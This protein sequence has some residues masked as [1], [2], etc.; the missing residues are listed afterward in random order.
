MAKDKEMLIALYDAMYAAFNARPS[1]AGDETSDER[2]PYF[3]LLGPGETVLPSDFAGAPLMG[4]NKGSAAALARFSAKVDT[5]PK[6]SPLYSPGGFISK[7]YEEFVTGAK[8]EDAPVSEEQQR[9]YDAASA[10]IWE[11]SAEGAAT[12][13]K[14]YLAYQ[15]AQSAYQ[16]SLAR[17]SA[18]RWVLD[19][20]EENDNRAWQIE[21]PQLSAEVEQAA[22]ALDATNPGGIESDLQTIARFGQS[23]PK[24]A[25]A[26]AKQSFDAWKLMVGNSQFLPTYALPS[27]WMSEGDAMASRWAQITVNARREREVSRS[28]LAK[29]MV[30]AD[31]EY[32]VVKMKG[33]VKGSYEDTE[34]KTDLSD[35]KMS[36]KF[37]RVDLVRP[38]LDLGLLSLKGISV[39]GRAPGAISDGKRLSTQAS[40]MPL[41]PTSMIV[42]K[43]ISIKGTWN[44]ADKKYFKIAAEVNGELAIGP[45]KLTG[46]GDG[47]LS[48]ETKNFDVS[49]DGTEIIVNGIQIIGYLNTIV[50]YSPTT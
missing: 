17:L 20:D 47:G 48:R 41:I 7:R 25:L 14:R 18:R 33:S 23:S 5:S 29:F 4:S 36:F 49:A 50:P 15:A 9:A 42:A 40:A 34:S 46:K 44:E 10:R 38:W 13:S 11:S 22:R 37:M 21:G 32:S 3:T 16:T 35:M 19:L 27:A 28:D 39:D 8:A 6:L 2:R 30:E 45:I 24:L 12:H 26:R 1:G 43:D 31:F